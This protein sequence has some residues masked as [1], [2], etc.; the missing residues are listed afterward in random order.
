M[1]N[2]AN[3]TNSNTESHGVLVSRWIITAV[4][5]FYEIIEAGPRAVLVTDIEI[6]STLKGNINGEPYVYMPIHKCSTTPHGRTFRDL[7]CNSWS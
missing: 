4:S 1:I 7:L 6:E 5:A 3:I 2:Q